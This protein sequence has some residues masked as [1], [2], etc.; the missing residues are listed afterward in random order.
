MSD[1]VQVVSLSYVVKAAGL[2]GTF[3]RAP[4]SVSHLSHLRLMPS[5]IAILVMLLVI[6]AFHVPNALCRLVYFLQ[7]PS[8]VGTIV[9]PSLQTRKLSHQEIKG[10]V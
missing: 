4:V 5:E 1:V 2:D 3:P 8:E 10:F 7:Q 9:T 6:A